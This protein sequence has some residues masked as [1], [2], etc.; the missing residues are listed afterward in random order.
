VKLVFRTDDQRLVGASVMG[1]GACELIHVPAA[2]LQFGGTLDY[3]IQSVFNYP[4]LGDSFKYAAY[5]GLQRLQKRVSK[6]ME[7]RSRSMSPMTDDPMKG[8]GTA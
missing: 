7:A 8:S 2:V 4:T 5:D 1:E 3:F 6:A